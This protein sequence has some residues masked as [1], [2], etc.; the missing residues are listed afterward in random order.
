MWSTSTWEVILASLRPENSKNQVPP[1][2][3]RFARWVMPPMVRESIV[4]D[5][6]ERYRSPLQFIAETVRVLPFVIAGQFR[7]STE[8]PML[9]LQ[10]FILLACLGGFHP[11]AGAVP[12]WLVSGLPA[13][14]AFLVLLMRDVYRTQEQR[15]TRR[16]VIDTAMA[17]G[18][19]AAIEG[20]L[21]LLSQAGA[22]HPAW[23]LDKGFIILGSLSLPVLCVLRVSPALGRD[24]ARLRAATPAGGSA[25]EA[26]ADDYAR[27]SRGVRW[28]NRVEAGACLATAAMTA[29]VV[30]QTKPWVAPLSWLMFTGFVSI[31]VYLL[32]RGAAKAAPPAGQTDA[33]RG[34]Y[35]QEL[36]RQHRLRSFMWWWWLNPLFAGLITNFVM[37]GARQA[38]ATTVLMGLGFIYLLAYAI[39]H[40]NVTRGR[41]VV[42][43]IQALAAA[44]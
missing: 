22:V 37:A 25:A 39:H 24:D 30:V 17:A 14:V 20:L 6:L 16:A 36:Q 10:A 3:E 26:L 32:V 35:A 27:F 5:L 23:V 12:F 2:L 21:W 43:R 7:R 44:A 38:D 19:I 40:L 15:S 18:G 31:G 11:R 41:S 9:M 8:A 13:V 4:G 28:R 34:L 42:G 33:L 29:Y 1:A